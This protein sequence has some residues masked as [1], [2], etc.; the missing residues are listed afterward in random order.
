M[1]KGD[2]KKLRKER[3]KGGKRGRYIILIERSSGSRMELRDD[4]AFN[5]GGNGLYYSHIVS[6]FFNCCIEIC[7]C[8]Y[9]DQKYHSLAY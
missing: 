9:E 1:K 6:I 4:W 5:I 2:E 8:T 7:I 3:D